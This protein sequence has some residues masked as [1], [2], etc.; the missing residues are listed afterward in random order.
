M[1]LNIFKFINIAPEVNIS[2]T[3]FGIGKTYI[4]MNVGIS[5]VMWRRLKVRTRSL[6]TYPFECRYTKRCSFVSVSFAIPT[7]YEWFQSIYVYKDRSK[8]DDESEK[9][10]DPSTASFISSAEQRLTSRLKCN[11]FDCAAM[12][13]MKYELNL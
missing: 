8:G 3:S 2:T 5:R 1:K 12:F 7:F 6:Y 4:F 11:S 9:W 13:H 10:R